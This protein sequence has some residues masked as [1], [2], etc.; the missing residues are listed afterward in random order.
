M[1]SQLT[2]CSTLM[3]RQLGPPVN[4]KQ[5][6]F[7]ERAPRGNVPVDPIG[8]HHLGSDDGTNGSSSLTVRC[9]RSLRMPI[10]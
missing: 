8:E 6:R 2:H 7:A 3:I 10:R 4:S 1:E 5:T 9:Q